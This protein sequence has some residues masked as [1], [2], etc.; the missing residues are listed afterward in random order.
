[1]SEKLINEIK[2][3]QQ[4]MMIEEQSLSGLIGNI[5]GTLSNT[6]TLDYLSNNKKNS[7]PISGK[8]KHRYSG[9]AGEMVNK[10]IQEMEKM[11]ITNPNTQIGLLSVIGKESGFITVKEKGYCNT[12]DSRIINIFGGRGRKCKSLKCDDPK[13]F[14]CV[15]GK[16]SGV[17]LGNTQPG[18]GWKYVGRG[19]NGITGRGNY[20]M[21]GQ[22][23]GVDLENNPELLE[24]P[25]IAAKAALAFFLKGKNPKSLPNFTDKESAVK[26]FADINAGKKSESSRIAALKVLPKFDIA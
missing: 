26:Y 25:E 18:D 13:F 17:R 5:M 1:M 4:L 7:K 3:T 19:L 20:K 22:M 21:Y 11:G 8:I 14:E 23:I 16:G 9:K 10:M 6:G 12:D 24:R 2:R 15:Y